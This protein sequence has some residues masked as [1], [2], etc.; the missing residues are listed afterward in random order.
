[1]LKTRILVASLL[2]ATLV[3]AQAR[4][5]TQIAADPSTGAKTITSAVSGDVVLGP[6]SGRGSATIQFTGTWTGTYPIQGSLD[7]NCTTS[8][9]FATLPGTSSL[10]SNGLTTVTVSGIRCIKIPASGWS[11][12]TTS[13]VMTAS[14]A[15][16]GSGGGTG[17]SVSITQGGNTAA[18]NASSQLSVTCA[19]CTGTGVSLNDN[20]VV[21]FSSSPLT[22]GGG[23]VDDV[24]T[25]TVTENAGA[26]FRMTPLSGLHI[27]LRTQAG[28]E[29]GI[30]ALPLQV[31][32]ANTAAN[33]T[34]V[35][36]DGSA[37]T[38]PVSGTVTANLGTGTGTV[39]GAKTN[40]NAAPGGTNVGVIG[41]LANAADP[42]W[43]EG[44]LVAHSVN[45][46][47]YQRTILSAS[48]PT[49]GTKAPGT[50][51]ANAELVGG[52][53]TAAGV[54]LTNGQQAALQLNSAGALVTAAT[55]SGA[56]D[57]ELPAAA[58][59][60]DATANPTVPGVGAFLMGWN[61]TTWDRFR[62]SSDKTEEVA[63]SGGDTGPLILGVRR[64]T[65][66][67]SSTATSRFSTFNLSA[68]GAVYTGTIDPCSYL[69][70]SYQPINISTATTTVLV[71][72]SASNKLYV[73]D[74]DVGPTSAAQNFA[75]V[76]DAT[77]ACAS[78][79]AGISG[80]TT[81]GSG[82]N[83]GAN[84]G[85]V[86]GNGAA[87]VMKTAS[88]NVNVCAITSAAAQI[89]GGMTYVLAP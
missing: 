22:P 18:V 43:T 32:L 60:A 38:Q 48:N 78:P 2:M 11:S 42:S 37:V 72:A 20:T 31:S 26:F 59:L 21:T 75:L 68:L 67:S 84:G 81:A 19:N 53:Y 23:V 1:M 82:W 69:S 80:G 79:D 56:V 6:L 85:K 14:S 76:E 30:A 77:A 35:K 46:T 29:T 73:C 10:T 61:G 50:A 33:A 3:P 88:T 44:N 58:A 5:Q 51:A 57:T 36:V 34:A 55:F 13:V 66:A 49:Y 64:D 54:T 8:G 63:E 12:G 86:V 25:R 17:S 15:G 24:A 87:T 9:T 39:A 16:G 70:K 62:P 74:I 4:A 45:L 47:G 52:V 27:N 83:V 65:P 28:A 40:N 89:S 41:A 71:A 7:R